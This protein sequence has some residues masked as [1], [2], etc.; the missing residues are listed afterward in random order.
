MAEITLRPAH[1]DDLEYLLKILPVLDNGETL[2]SLNA[3]RAIFATIKANSNQYLFVAEQNAE[4]V[5]ALILVI[6]QQFSHAGG[7]SLIV[8][9]V[10]VSQ[11][12]QG[13][14]VGRQMMQFAADFGRKHGCYK[15]NLCSG[16][17]RELAH[18][19]YRKLGYQQHG[20]SFLLA[21]D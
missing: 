9:D 5:G 10:M 6:V 3:I 2:L 8:E 4:L 17:A 13:Q 11:S 7:K 19:F 1:D 15:I 18:E 16:K 20:I 21:L 12:H 14:G